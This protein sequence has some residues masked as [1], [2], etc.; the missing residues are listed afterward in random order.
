VGLDQTIV[1]GIAVAAGLFLAVLFRRTH[2]GLRMRAVVGDPE[3]T[4][5]MG[6]DARAVKTLAW[7]LGCIFAALSGVLFAP[8]VGLDAVLLTLLVIQAFG[9]AV[10]GRLRHLGLT[11]LGAYGIAILAAVST[12]YAAS[13]PTLVGLPS[14][15]PFIVLF[16]VLVIAPKGFFAEVRDGEASLSGRLGSD[17]RF[18]GVTLLSMG[19]MAAVLPALLTGSQLLT[20]TT[21]VIFVA[22]FSSLGLLVGLSRQVSLC[23]AVFAVFGATTLSHLIHAGGPYGVALLLGALVLVPLGAVV[24]IPAIRLSGLF[25]ALATFG[26]GILA[27]S[28][29]YNTSFVFGRSAQVALPRPALFTGDTG[30]YYFTLAVVVVLVGIVE[31][32]RVT[33]LG[34]IAQAIGDAPQAVESLGIKPTTSRVMI[35]CLAAFIAGVAGGL[36]GSL[37]GS[38]TSFTFGFANSLVWLTVLIAAG[39]FSLGGSVLAAVLLV[40]VPAVFTSET[41]TQW[42][43]VAFGVAAILLA[44]APNGL[45]GFVRR[46]DFATLARRDAW[47]LDRRRTLERA[48]AVAAPGGAI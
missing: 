16:A 20:A 37:V 48:A 11:N 17:R 33:R 44:Q 5:L 1:V 22:L 35:F 45:A 8:V 15:L 7:M 23:H 42:Q 27:E 14:S 38:I 12:R 34:R 30:F 43:P 29:L 39:P 2:T 32:V 4:E 10:V 21:T 18:P 28:L 47:R 13:T 3:L 36:L 31:A 46:P 19:A 25:L 6:T 41:V 9:A 24:A 26:F 40:A